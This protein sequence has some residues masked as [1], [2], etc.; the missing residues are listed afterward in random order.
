MTKDCSMNFLGDFERMYPNDPDTAKKEY[1]NHKKWMEELVWNRCG[2]EMEQLFEWYWKGVNY[3]GDSYQKDKKWIEV[4]CERVQIV[5]VGGEESLTTYQKDDR[6]KL[7]NKTKFRLYFCAGGFY[8]SDGNSRYS[9]EETREILN[10]LKQNG[11]KLEEPVKEYSP[12][13]IEFPKG[14]IFDVKRIRVNEIP[15]KSLGDNQRSY[16]S[17]YNNLTISPEGF[18][19]SIEATDSITGEYPHNSKYTDFDKIFKK[20]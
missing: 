11:V 13:Y 1:E 7:L 14:T 8:K 10:K 12:Y 20:L 18:D 9:E 16:K 17:K 5:S 2:Y 4:L 6:L 3:N 15:S 19:M